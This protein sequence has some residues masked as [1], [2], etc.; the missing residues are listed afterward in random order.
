M[1]CPRLASEF[2]TSQ[3]RRAPPFSEFPVEA[4]IQP[5][6]PY[7]FVLVPNGNETWK[8]TEPSTVL[9]LRS[10]APWLTLENRWKW[11]IEISDRILSKPSRR[12]SSTP[13]SIAGGYL[14]LKE[15]HILRMIQSELW[16]N[17]ADFGAKL[18]PGDRL[19]F[20]PKTRRAGH[21]CTAESHG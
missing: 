20:R 9:T 16:R 4:G 13:R 1:A 10:S 14:S 11:T 15:T 21:I 5:F 2:Q 3:A 19:H 12:F 18:S 8:Q 17:L 6:D 7:G